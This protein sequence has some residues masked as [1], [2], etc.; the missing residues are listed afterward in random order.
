MT[1]HRPN[2][3]QEQRILATL[4][5]V[6]AGK[7]DIPEEYI[8]RHPPASAGRRCERALLQTAASYQRMQRPHK[9]AEVKG[10]RHRDEP[11]ND[12]HGFAY[13]RLAFATLS[14]QLAQVT[15]P[16]SAPTS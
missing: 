2:G 1:H 12:A 7:H 4:Q 6:A 15:K 9:R 11:G 10:P 5:A 3:T 16:S 13:H 8:R 14:D